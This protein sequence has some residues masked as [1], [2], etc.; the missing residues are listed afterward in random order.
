MF[1]NLNQNCLHLSQIYIQKNKEVTINEIQ[2][3]KIVISKLLNK[4]EQHLKN[5]DKEFLSHLLNATVFGFRRD[6]CKKA[7]KY[8]TGVL[9]EKILP[10]YI[11][12]YNFVFM[13]AT[14]T[15]GLLSDNPM[16]I[17]SQLIYKKHKIDL[18]MKEEQK[19][20][21]ILVLIK[22]I[23]AVS[24]IIQTDLDFKGPFYLINLYNIIDKFNELFQALFDTRIFDI[25]SVLEPHKFA[26]HSIA[27]AHFIIE[28]PKDSGNLTKEDIVKITPRLVKWKKDNEMHKYIVEGYFDEFYKISLE[29]IRNDLIILSVFICQFLLFFQ[30]LMQIL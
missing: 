10:S 18:V 22:E 15:N 23:Y 3:A 14:A 5:L 2:E 8:L 12:A 17:I 13:G 20:L 1:N 26:R 19:C 24:Q 6:N 25:Y 4:S 28:F 11:P 21:S 9:M 27:H 29:D 30:Y 16:D 7:I